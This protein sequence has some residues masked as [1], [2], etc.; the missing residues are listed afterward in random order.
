[1]A[2]PVAGRDDDAIAHLPTT[3]ESGRRGRVAGPALGAGLLA[4]LSVPPAGW[5]PLGLVGVGLAGALLAGRPA[6]TRALIGFSAGIGLYGI[7]LIWLTQFNFFGGLLV[8]ALESGFLALAAV[9][10]PEGR[11]RIVA[12][13]AALA[14]TTALRTVFP[15][16]GLPMG[17][18]ELGQAA[19]PLAP[20]ARLGGPLLL[21]AVTTA[22]GV[23]LEMLVRRRLVAGAVALALAVVL[24]IAGGAARDGRVVGSLRVAAVQAGGRRGL[25]AVDNPPVLVYQAQLQADARL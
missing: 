10:T 19:G 23:A 1:M 3:S 8:I 7:T 12:W 16:G 14:A 15:F 25:R 18:V 6:R 2:A 21:I 24:P 4:G 22:A 9:A 5:W 13:P 20:A 17:G 11:G